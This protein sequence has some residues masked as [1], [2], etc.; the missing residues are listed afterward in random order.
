MTGLPLRRGSDKSPQGSNVK[1]SRGSRSLEERE[2][3]MTPCILQPSIPHL[4]SAEQSSQA[5]PPVFSALMSSST[6]E[7]LANLTS[8][9]STDK[10]PFLHPPSP[11]YDKIRQ[12]DQPTFSKIE[13]MAKI[14]RRIVFP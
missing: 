11:D 2:K 6:R 5:L 14:A 7:Y 9:H 3:E 4:W 12:L 13:I 8:R 1:D 10:A